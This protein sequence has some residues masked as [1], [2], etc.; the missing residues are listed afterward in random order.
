MNDPARES[1]WLALSELWLDADL[2]EADLAAIAR[3]LA[4]S[5]FSVAELESIYRLEVAPVVWANTWVTAG[6]WDGFDPDWL[7]EACR[8]NQ[9]RRHSLWHRGRCRLLKRAMTY[10]TDEHWRRIREQLSAG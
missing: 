6:V 2:D 8:R 7:F 5:G 1:V 4:I 10:A 3:T 9:R